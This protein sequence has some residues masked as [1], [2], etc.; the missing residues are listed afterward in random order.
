MG[1]TLGLDEAR[2]E[3]SAR[4]VPLQSNGESSRRRSCEAR[5]ELARP[6]GRQS[7]RGFALIL[8]IWV[9]A[10][11]SVIAAVMAADVHAGAVEARNRLDLAQ[12]R[13]TADAGVALAIEGL[14]NPDQTARWQADGRP[15]AVEYDGSPVE[16]H[17][18]DEGG[19]ID[20]NGAPIELIAGLLDEFGVAAGQRSALTQAILRRRSAFAAAALAAAAKRAIEDRFR[21]RRD[22]T[23]TNA[24]KL[25]FANVSEVRLIPGMT[26][27]L[28]RQLLPYLTTYSQSPTI[29][30]LTAPRAILLA[31]PG[32]SPDD[33]DAFLAARAQ[34]ADQPTPPPL[35][36]AGRYV[37][38]A[39]LRIV[40]I[41]A[42]AGFA[43]PARFERQAVV[44][45]SPNLP[46]DE[47]RVL[48]WR[49]ARDPA[50]A[51]PAA[52]VAVGPIARN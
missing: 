34:A 7:E 24:D 32:I 13:A 10:L 1:E 21:F 20:L 52:P 11:L 4:V 31:I 38:I 39:D 18:T 33:V 48:E 28:Y 2:A 27:E 9:L 37:R 3:R 46:L 19:K 40:T 43:G 30:P 41:N 36:G 17:V 47:V 12:A 45:A 51:D 5:G 6:P 8:E 26:G 49:L 25:A 50:A 22:V 44:L 16:V 29:N 14:L 35:P 42:Q 23:F 15:Y